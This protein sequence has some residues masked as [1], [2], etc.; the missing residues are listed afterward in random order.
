[1]VGCTKHARAYVILECPLQ[2]R[3]RD[4]YIEAQRQGDHAAVVLVDRDDREHVALACLDDELERVLAGPLD[5]VVNNAGLMIEQHE[6]EQRKAA[7]RGGVG[8]P[9]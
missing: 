5:I 9:G 6:L 3:A 8:E 1:M 7:G 4:L 2:V